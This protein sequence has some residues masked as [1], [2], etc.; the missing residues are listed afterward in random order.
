MTLF[1][2]AVFVL[3]AAATFAAFFVAQRLKSTPQVAAIKQI[4]RHFSPNADGRRD[5]SR[6]AVRVRED[7]DVT[8]S[9][10]DEADNEVRRLAEAVPA[11]EQKSVRV[12]W[13]GRT[14]A[15]GRAPEAE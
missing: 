3:L 2:R 7:D 15:G 12:S 13:D 11:V 1:A 14:E 10:V 9:I 4:T 6:I 8:I 5:V